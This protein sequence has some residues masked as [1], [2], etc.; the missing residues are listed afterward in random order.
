MGIPKKKSFAPDWKSPEFVAE[1]FDQALEDSGFRMN[2]IAVSLCPN[3]DSLE[4]GNH[5]LNCNLCENGF[6][7]T[8]TTEFIGIL[9]SK[10]IERVYRVA[11]NWEGGTAFLTVPSNVRISYQD[12]IEMPDSLS[13][14][15]QL[16]TKSS[17]KIDKTRY[18]IKKIQFLR[19]TGK[20][21]AVNT[22]FAVT[23][24]GRIEWIAKNR[25]AEGEIFTIRYEYHTRY[26]VIDLLNEAR[27]ALI[28]RSNEERIH[29]RMPQ[30]ALVKL[31]YLWPDSDKDGNV[32]NG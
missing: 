20:E 9:T 31:D 7:E 25:P 3:Y 10:G 22:D 29:T 11:G 13:I 30:H 12:I 24:D 1:W 8:K 17:T 18:R 16:I 4:R 28:S 23:D 21:Y 14:Y 32:N 19:T 26:R 5:N 6:V 2:H 15:T 27:D